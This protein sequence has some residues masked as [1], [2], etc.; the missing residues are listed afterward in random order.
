MNKEAEMK[1]EQLMDR[2]PISAQIIVGKVVS[3]MLMEALKWGY[4]KGI[5][6]QIEWIELHP[7]EEKPLDNGEKPS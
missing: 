7:E 3:E 1:V 5:N 6:T 4:E 2:L